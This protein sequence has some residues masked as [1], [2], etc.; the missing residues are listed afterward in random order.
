MRHIEVAALFVQELVHQKDLKVGKVPGHANPANCL[1]KHLDSTLKEQC[2]HELSMVD[3]STSDL[4]QVLQDAA[5]VELVAS[6]IARQS[7]PNKLTPW[8]PNFAVAVNALQ[9]C[10]AHMCYTHITEA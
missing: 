5:Q 1:T 6:L 9:L 3:M 8:K 7:A 2:L 10:A 4:R